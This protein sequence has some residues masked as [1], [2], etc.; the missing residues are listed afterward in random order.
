MDELNN[1]DFSEGMVRSNEN[2]LADKAAQKKALFGF[3]LS[4]VNGQSTNDIQAKK[5][6]PFLGGNQN[7]NIHNVSSAQS[8]SGMN[9]G[10]D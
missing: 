3:G 4:P 1:D 2:I 10:S 5:P 7:Q 9:R 6:S 8:M